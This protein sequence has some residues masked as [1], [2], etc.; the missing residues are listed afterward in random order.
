MEDGLLMLATSHAA[1]ARDAADRFALQRARREERYSQE[2]GTL[3][4]W[5]IAALVMEGVLRKWILT[6]IQGPLVFLREPFLILIYFRYISHFGLRK[7][8]VFPYLLL[9]FLMSIYALMQAMANEY[10]PIVAAFGI[11]FYIAYIPLAFMMGDS[12][13]ERQLIRIILFLLK[14]S[15]PISI[16]VMLQ[17]FSPA[18]STIN[19]DISDEAKNIFTVTGDIVRPYGPFSFVAGQNNFAG[20]M[21]AI[22]I[23]AI[24]Q[25]K[26]FKI[27]NTLLIISGFSVLT[28]GA[29]SGGRTYFGYLILVFV[30]YILAGLTSPNSSA[31]IKRLMIAIAF[32]I[33]FIFVFVIVFP[34]SFE[35]MTT[36]QNE[37]AAYEGSTLGRV[38]SSL[39]EFLEPFS[40]APIF[41]AGLGIGSNMAQAVLPRTF[42]YGEFTLY[43]NEWPRMIAELG[44]PIGLLILIMRFLLTLWIGWIALVANR[45]NNQPAGMI[46]FGYAGFLLFSGQVTLQNQLLSFCWLSIGLVIAFSR[47]LRGKQN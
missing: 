35:A 10:T 4:I 27:S 2:F 9:F 45:R 21:T 34:S 38:L 11:R 25:R 30:A 15:I 14:I 5:F 6:P 39:I 40:D 32:A 17:F 33:S 16:L 18:D 12:L 26:R 8:W 36:R 24:D 13:N 41:G 46:M 42:E 37:A 47:Q 43:E 19:K 1:P 44:P 28:Q 22:F 20:M 3:I 23:I 29:L 7:K 31:G